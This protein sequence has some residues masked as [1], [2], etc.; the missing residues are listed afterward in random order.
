MQSFGPKFAEENRNF[1]KV[2][3]AYERYRK[4]SEKKKHSVAQPNVPTLPNLHVYIQ[5][6]KSVG[7]A[8]ELRN[9]IKFCNFYFF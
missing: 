4:K 2:N 1:F 7:Y 9:K 8:S 5:Q 3:I 6:P